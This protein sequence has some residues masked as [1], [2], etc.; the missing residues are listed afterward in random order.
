MRVLL[1]VFMVS[2][3]MVYVEGKSALRG[4]FPQPYPMKRKEGFDPGQP[5]FLT[6]FVEKGMFDEGMFILDNS[7]VFSCLAD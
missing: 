5:V 6:P 2:M 7:N 4:M 3:V 1:L